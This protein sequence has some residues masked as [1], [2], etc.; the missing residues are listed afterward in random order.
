MI[1]E[2]CQTASAFSCYAA[3]FVLN[4]FTHD[5]YGPLLTAYSPTAYFYGIYLF[6][7]KNKHWASKNRTQSRMT[8][9]RVFLSAFKSEAWLGFMKDFLVFK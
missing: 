7:Q 4:P 8:I 9:A 2:I 5:M 6:P 3:C 1:P